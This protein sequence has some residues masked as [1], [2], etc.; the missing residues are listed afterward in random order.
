M[1]WPTPSLDDLI[2]THDTGG[3]RWLHALCL[4]INE[5]EGCLGITKTQFVKGDGSENSDLALADFTGLWVGGVRDG[6]ITNLNRCM[7]AV[8]A[9]VK[10]PHPFFPSFP[11]FDYEAFSVTSGAGGGTYSMA[12][13]EAAVGLGAFP[14]AAD[15]WVD[16]NFWK[17]IQGA[18]DLMIYGRRQVAATAT[19]ISERTTAVLY[20]G[21]ADAWAATYADTPAIVSGGGTFG[22]IELVVYDVGFGGYRAIFREAATITVNTM[23]ITGTLTN[24]YLNVYLIRDTTPATIPASWQIGSHTEGS[25]IGTN[26]IATVDVALGVLNDFPFSYNYTPTATW[27]VGF[28]VAVPYGSYGTV[29]FADLYFDI[30]AELTDQA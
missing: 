28:G 1:A 2:V 3:K 24:S 16:L 14:V 19:G 21:A 6:A 17:Q 15:S 8:K 20:A 23:G 27:P 7:A 30:S 5:R 13:L 22:Q 12:E 18:L 29:N 26:N 25:L 11:I 10:L 4:A 9:M